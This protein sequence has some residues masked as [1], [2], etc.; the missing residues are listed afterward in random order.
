VVIGERV[1]RACRGDECGVG[2]RRAMVVAPVAVVEAGTSSV[3]LDRA[4]FHTVVRRS[5]EQKERQ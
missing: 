5:G 1:R 2:A 4:E 3:G